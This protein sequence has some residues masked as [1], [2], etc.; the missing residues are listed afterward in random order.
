MDELTTG[1]LGSRS[2]MLDFSW[3]TTTV[4]RYFPYLAQSSTNFS[5]RFA[6]ENWRRSAVVMNRIKELEIQT[7]PPRP[8]WLSTDR[9]PGKRRLIGLPR[10]RNGIGYGTG[11]SPTDDHRLKTLMAKARRAQ[12]KGG[13]HM[14]K[15]P[16]RATCTDGLHAFSRDFVYAICSVPNRSPTRDEFTLAAHAHSLISVA[17]WNYFAQERRLFRLSGCDDNEH[18][19]NRPL[20]PVHCLPD[21]AWR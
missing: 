8:T 10:S 2:E 17:V 11:T 4:A 1:R 14:R 19:H 12:A 7:F 18:A 6:A 3:P 9:S 15:I 13:V 20:Q 21:P 16:G 5:A